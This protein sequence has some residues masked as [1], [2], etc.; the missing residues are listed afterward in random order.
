MKLNKELKALK[1]MLVKSPRVNEDYI[2]LIKT[3]ETNKETNF[4]VY[5]INKQGRLKQLRDCDFDY[6]TKIFNNNNELTSTA[7]KEERELDCYFQIIETLLIEST[8]TKN[9]KSFNSIE[10]FLKYL[11]INLD[12]KIKKT[13]HECENNYN[14]IPLFSFNEN[15]QIIYN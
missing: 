11:I 5:F 3:K 12:L 4:L 6:E 9:Y 10:E 2:F 14:Y 1:N 8:N 15:E 7:N 13:K